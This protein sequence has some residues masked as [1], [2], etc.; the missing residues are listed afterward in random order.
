[1]LALSRLRRRAAYIQAIRQ[2][3]I[4]QD[5][6]EV[7]TPIRIPAS[8]PEAHIEPEVCGSWFLQTSPELCMKRL[9]AVGSPAL[10]Q[11]CKCFRRGERGDR[12]LPEFTMLEWYRTGCDYLELMADCEQLLLFLADF[13]HMGKA[14]R[15]GGH[16]IAL[17]P[18]WERLTVAEAF[19]RHAP[20]TLGE[21]LANGI[22][23]EMLC[24]YIEP[25]LGIGGP[26]FLC[27]YPAEL[28]SLARIK[29]TDPTVA[30]RFELYVGGIELANGFSELTDPVEQRQRF[31]R[32]QAMIWACN[33]Q[34]GPMPENFLAALAQLE[35]AAGIALGIDRL[36]MVLW[37][38][39]SIDEVVTFTPEEL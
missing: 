24:N 22:F 19:R 33:R 25:Q 32:E 27:D 16:T 14:I 3:F 1:M 38:A 34:S 6:V 9:L 31:A 37:G 15:V 13:F 26:V 10:F 5:F 12:H 36:A 8:A 35:K 28:A 18:P 17:K 4:N 2:Y 30:E 29:E 23:D 11:I 21:S 20:Q 7:D 39:A